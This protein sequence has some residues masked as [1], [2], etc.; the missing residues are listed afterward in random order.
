MQPLVWT[1]G[2]GA[3][4]TVLNWHVQVSLREPRF[5][6]LAAH[7]FAAKHCVNLL[8]NLLQQIREALLLNF[9]PLSAVEL[10]TLLL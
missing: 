5:E 4:R 1:A 9:P 8:L 3:L 6:M 7:C 2:R 10:S